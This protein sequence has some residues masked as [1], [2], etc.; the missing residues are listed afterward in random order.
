MN[1][2]GMKSWYQINLFVCMY[3]GYMLY[4]FNRKSFSFVIPTIVEKNELDKQSIGKVLSSTAAAYA[5]GK[6]ANGV[7]VD[8]FSSRMMFAAGLFISGLANLLFSVSSP[9]FFSILGFVNG[10][11]QGPGWPACA[12]ILRRWYSPKTFGTLWSTL[13]TSMNVP[14]SIGPLFCSVYVSWTGG[15]WQS[16]MLMAGTLSCGFAFASLFILKDK[17]EDVGLTLEA[18]TG[19]TASENDSPNAKENKT[20]DSNQTPK[21]NVVK[22]IFSSIYTYVLMLGFAITLFVRGVLGNWGALYLIQD[23]NSDNYFASVFIAWYEF[24]GVFGSVFTGYLSDLL[25]S[26]FGVKSRGHPRHLIVICWN[27]V[28]LL[29]LHL[30]RSVQEVESLATTTLVL[31]FVIGF[32]VYGNISMCGVLAIENSAND[33]S[34]TS[35]AFCALAGSLG[36]TLSGLPFS[37]LVEAISWND[38]MFVCQGLILTVLVV[39]LVSQR[40]RCRIGD[41]IK[42]D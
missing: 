21:Q 40:M 28:L 38:A 10:F 14:A 11:T 13:S 4:I 8:R 32:C 7:L 37:T 16:V 39:F 9:T 31:G 41:V 19:E 6:F 42:Q 3:I 17:P 18:L 23:K 20:E 2:F 30:L 29:S 25:V 22:R 33:I 26:T 34:G 27:V 1:I 24:G 15:S 12:K 5:I 36:L 35:H